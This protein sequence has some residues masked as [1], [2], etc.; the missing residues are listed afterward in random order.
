MN[1]FISKQC[2]YNT[3]EKYHHRKSTCLPPRGKVSKWAEI[4]TW[5]E[6]MSGKQPVILLDVELLV[7]F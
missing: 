5:E 2:T 1:L 7:E 3:D 6:K 4:D